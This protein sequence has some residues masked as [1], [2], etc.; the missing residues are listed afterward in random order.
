MELEI[1]EY[2]GKK[3]SKFRTFN[4]A[5]NYVDIKSETDIFKA[6]EYAKKNDLSLFVLGAGSNVFFKQTNVKSFVLK[7]ALEKKIEKLSENKFEVSSSVMVLDLLKFL[8]SQKLDAP[9]YLA[10]AP[11][12]VGGAIAMNAGTGP[13]EAKAIFDFVESVKF[14]RNGKIEHL[15]ADKIK[16]SHRYTELSKDAFIISAVFN[17]PST[18]FELDPVKARLDW[19]VK[20]QDLSLP[21]CGSLC[22]KYNASIMKFTRLLFKPFPAGMSTKKLNW[23]YNKADNPIYLRAFLFTLKTLH[24]LFGKEI[25]FEIKMIN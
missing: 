25:K 15:P 13:K 18:E 14:F 12:E 6:F 9:Y 1:K 17:F 20:N 5:K 24:R 8:Y 21:N 11:C 4:V 22:N 10:S 23:T 2:R 3:L 16:H 19:A 7:N